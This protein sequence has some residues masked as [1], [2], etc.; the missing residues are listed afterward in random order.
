[1][2]VSLAGSGEDDHCLGVR[3]GRPWPLAM[4]ARLA[5]KLLILRLTAWERHAA[6]EPEV[7]RSGS[8]R[9]P[10]RRRWRSRQGGPH[11]R[12]LV[13]VTVLSVVG[14]LQV[15]PPCVPRPL[16]TADTRILGSATFSVIGSLHPEGAKRRI[17]RVARSS[18]PR[19]TWLAVLACLADSSLDGGDD[20]A[21]SALKSQGAHDLGEDLVLGAKQSV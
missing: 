3:S 6:A 2:P 17:R 5:V 9:P 16:R 15:W 14:H 21:A 8:R 19:C 10:A 13:P 4:V 12:P 11:A 7:V 20:S 1:M 18:R